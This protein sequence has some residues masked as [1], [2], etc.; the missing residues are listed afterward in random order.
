MAC[1]KLSHPWLWTVA[2]LAQ[3]FVRFAPCCVTVTNRCAGCQVA[4]S[5]DQGQP[6]ATR[7][8]S[9]VHPT[10]VSRMV[11]FWELFL[12]HCGCDCRSLDLELELTSRPYHV[13]GS[14][15]ALGSTPR[16]GRQ[17]SWHQG[18]HMDSEG[19]FGGRGS[20]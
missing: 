14:N 17:Q 8:T 15:R 4:Q 20:Q 7:T 9:W 2:V 12:E 10:E 3:L 19:W 18:Q 6:R 1:R 16:A 5:G 11:H 13:A